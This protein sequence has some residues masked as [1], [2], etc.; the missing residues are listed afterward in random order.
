MTELT[1]DVNRKK[2]CRQ[3]IDGRLRDRG[4]HDK[5]TAKGTLSVVRRGVMIAS[6]PWTIRRMPPGKGLVPITG[7]SEYG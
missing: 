3:G 2:R 5:G 6:A 7:A 1:D 4:V